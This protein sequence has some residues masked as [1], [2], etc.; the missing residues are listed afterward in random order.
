MRHKRRRRLRNQ[1]ARRRR[2]LRMGPIVNGIPSAFWKIL[3]RPNPEL[4]ALALKILTEP[5]FPRIP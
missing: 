1:R 2:D 3:T 4:D 5:L